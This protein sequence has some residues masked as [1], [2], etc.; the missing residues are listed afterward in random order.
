MYITTGVSYG[1]QS[2]CCALSV[3]Q[4]E[5]SCFAEGFALWASVLQEG[6]RGVLANAAAASQVLKGY[7]KYK[8]SAGRQ[9]RPVVR[10]INTRQTEMSHYA[11]LL[12]ATFTNGAFEDIKKRRTLDR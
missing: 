5:R 6:L 3:S 7:L 12:C 1:L 8:I 2:L 11:P 4:S 9:K 10:G